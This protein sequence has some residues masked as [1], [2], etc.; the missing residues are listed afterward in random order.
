MSEGAG[1]VCM[2]ECDH[3]DC[4]YDCWSLSIVS[5]VLMLVV[6]LVLKVTEVTVLLYAR[7]LMSLNVQ[8]N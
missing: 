3:T 8:T 6:V 7:Q 2:Y 4:H 1:R 5:A